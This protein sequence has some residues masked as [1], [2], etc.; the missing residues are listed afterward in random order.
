MH[1]DQFGQFAQALLL[2]FLVLH[3]FIIR[4]KLEES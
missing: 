1:A 4:V 3:A 2:L